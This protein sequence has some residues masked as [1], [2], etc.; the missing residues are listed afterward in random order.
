MLFNSYEFIFFFFPIVTLLFFALPH[1][2]RWIHL[3]ISSCLFYM[4]FVPVYILILA[5]TILVDYFVG[6]GLDTC[7][8]DHK[9]RLIL[10]GSLV[11]NVGA[12]ALFK[13]FN[14][15]NENLAVLA[16]AIGWSYTISNLSLVLPIGL[17]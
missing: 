4:W 14:F 9:R 13:Y 1:R 8:S 7:A 5:A 11:A 6:L 16:K 15:V 2:Y 17:S 12:L 3:L 10:I